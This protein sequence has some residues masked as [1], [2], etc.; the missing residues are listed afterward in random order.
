MD[1]NTDSSTC[2][3]NLFYF[4]RFS[5]F[6][7]KFYI[8]VVFS[9]SLLKL[10]HSTY[11]STH[12]MFFGLSN[13]YETLFF[14]STIGSD[15]YFFSHVSKC[16][17]YIFDW[18]MNQFQLFISFSSILADARFTFHIFSYALCSMLITI[19]ER[20]CSWCAFFNPAWFFFFLRP[21]ALSTLFLTL[22]GEIII[23]S[24]YGYK[25]RGENAQ[26]MSMI[27]YSMMWSSMKVWN[28]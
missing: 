18:Y 21:R 17:A 14:P 11:C 8:R 3:P 2:N 6:I 22:G 20:V 5:S 23:P 26:G 9:L 19:F 24:F 4:C 27:D 13:S 15:N 7:F 12:F 28:I 16:T 25:A 10:L 1:K